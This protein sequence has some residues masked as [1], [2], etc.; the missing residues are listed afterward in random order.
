MIGCLV[1]NKGGKKA[2]ICTITEQQ[3]SLAV[4]SCD[5][6]IYFTSI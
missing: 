5:E 2:S 6:W 1:K 3:L 4:I